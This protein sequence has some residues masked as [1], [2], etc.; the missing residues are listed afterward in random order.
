V[1]GVAGDAGRVDGDPAVVVSAYWPLGSAEPL[2]AGPAP[3]RSWVT[4]APPSWPEPQQQG[5]GVADAAFTAVRELFL[6]A[7]PVAEYVHPVRVDRDGDVAVLV[8]RWRADPRS[9]AVRVDLPLALEL[10]DEG[11]GG[12]EQWTVPEPQTGFPTSGPAGWADG[13]SGWL[14]EQL[15]TGAIRGTTRRDGELVVVDLE[16]RATGDGDSAY[17]LSSG[18]WGRAAHR[19]LGIDQESVPPAGVAAA[20]GFPTAALVAAGRAATLVSWP[21]AWVNSSAGGPLVGQAV[22]VADPPAPGSPPSATSATLVALD[23]A[24]P[25]PAG[26]WRRGWW[27]TCSVTPPMPESPPWTGSGHRCPRGRGGPPTPPTPAGSTSTSDPPVPARQPRDLPGR[28]RIVDGL[29]AHSEPRRGGPAGREPP[30]R[31]SP[32]TYARPSVL[33]SF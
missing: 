4:R 9:F 31:S 15:L 28:T 2:V 27:P 6:A 13:L 22:C 25:T 11:W 10:V 20:A 1:G 23:V 5:P 8:F 26:A 32:A 18:T 29:A 16:D 17:Y 3:D 14:E 12:G 33:T 21:L 24:P 7:P 30:V 19:A